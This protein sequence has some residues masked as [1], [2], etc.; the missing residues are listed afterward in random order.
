[1]SRTSMISSSASFMSSW[2]SHWIRRWILHHPR[3]LLIVWQHSRLLAIINWHQNLVL[4]E[5]SASLLEF[6]Q[7]Y[8]S[9][10]TARWYC[11]RPLAMSWL[12]FA[13]HCTEIILRF[14]HYGVSYSHFIGDFSL[15][16]AFQSSLCYFCRFL[17]CHILGI[18]NISIHSRIQHKE[19]IFR[20]L[21][22][23]DFD[24]GKYTVVSSPIPAF[25]LD[26]LVFP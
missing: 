5:S 6:L 11:S 8:N 21:L 12:I 1:M 7:N 2:P 15:K 22:I 26:F 9:C 16:Y 17:N 25:L 23:P 20:A 18:Q 24:F 19:T 3:R 13:D 10:C 14:F 4:M